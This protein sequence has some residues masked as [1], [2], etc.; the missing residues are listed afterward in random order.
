MNIELQKEIEHLKLLFAFVS[1]PFPN[2]K[3]ATDDEIGHI[4]DVTGLDLN[5]DIIDFYQFMNGSNREEIFAVFSDEETPCEFLS[6]ESALDAW[7]IKLSDIDGYYDSI[8]EQYD[9]Y[10]VDPP[11]DK[12]IRQDVWM[13]KRWFPFADFNGGGTRVYWDADPTPLGKVGQIIVYQHDPDGIY[14]VAEDF[15]TFLK[16]S[17][18]LFEGNPRDLLEGIYD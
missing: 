2:I 8:N 6:I 1:K 10:E 12:R 9:D 11:R 17:N 13:N 5:G 16:K 15:V 14:Y 18:D 7:G 3:G 4:R